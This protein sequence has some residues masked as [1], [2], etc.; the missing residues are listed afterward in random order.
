MGGAITCLALLVIGMRRDREPS[1]RPLLAP[2]AAPRPGHQ[3]VASSEGEAG[4][5]GKPA[6]FPVHI[7]RPD[8]PPVVE[9]KEPDALGRVGRIACATCHSV[10]PPDR[11]NRSPA[12]LDEFHTG[13]PF[14][15]GTL[16]CYSCHNP[17]DA[18]TLRLADETPVEYRDVMR[19]CAQCHSP[20]A[21]DYQR[22]S[23]GGVN[24]Y[25]DLTRGS[26]VRANCIDCHDPH[27]PRFPQML[28]TFKPHDRFL[29]PKHDHHTRPL[30]RK[31]LTRHDGT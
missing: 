9:L 11:K 29:V 30:D 17:D 26:R 24:G 5:R 18:D 3:Q 23:H 31:G 19:L 4:D 16:V 15:H 22:Y 12:D 14:R 25:W 10:R 27:V 1:D 13:M 21:G 7:R 8:G 28:P 20:Q 2:S 6:K